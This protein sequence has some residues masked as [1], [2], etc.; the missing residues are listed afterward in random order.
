MSSEEFIYKYGA[1]KPSA[2]DQ[3]VVF[4]CRA[5]VRSKEAMDIAQS[6]GYAK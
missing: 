3:N 4:H 5:G 1:A 2:D 6:L